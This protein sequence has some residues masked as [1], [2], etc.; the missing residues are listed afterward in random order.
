M[1]DRLRVTAPVARMRQVSSYLGDSERGLSDI[2]PIGFALGL[3][4]GVGLGLIHLPFPGGGFSLGAAAG[5]LLVG[6]VFGRLVRIG[7]V[8]VSMGHSAASTLSNFGMLTFLAYAG[9]RA[10][11]KFVA[12]VTSDI[13]WKA[14]LLGAVITTLAAAVVTWA[15][16][17]LLRTNSRQVAGM[18]AG[19]NTQPAV[20]AFANERTGFDVRVGLGY[21]LV[22]PAA[23]IA[24]I[25][26]AQILAGL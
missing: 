8:V 26:L 16:L 10:G 15:G 19:A 22:Y 6:L 21:A 5:T 18:L 7:P 3:A 12:S 11:E 23:M 14:L 1:G 2:N 13:G 20:L 4:L 9:S 24:K 17:V 25:L